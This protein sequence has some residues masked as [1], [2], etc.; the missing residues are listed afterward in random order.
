MCEH[1][2]V[3]PTADRPAGQGAGTEATHKHARTHRQARATKT[4]SDHIHPEGQTHEDTRTPT[5]AHTD[6]KNNRHAAA[7]A[8][9]K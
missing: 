9:T 7:H 6:N 5:D 8:I 3:V 4:Y 1:M 2:E